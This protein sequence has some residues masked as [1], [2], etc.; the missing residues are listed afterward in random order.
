[1]RL[2]IIGVVICVL[3][4]IFYLAF[5][6]LYRRY[7]GT[8]RVDVEFSPRTVVKVRSRLPSPPTERRHA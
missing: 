4:C 8:T 2:I 6:Q 1:V 3:P 7:Y 5:V